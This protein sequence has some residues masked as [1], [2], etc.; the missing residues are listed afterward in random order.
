MLSAVFKIAVIGDPVAS[1]NKAEFK[2]KTME[3]F[4]EENYVKLV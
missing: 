2:Q 4:L 3:I 1:C